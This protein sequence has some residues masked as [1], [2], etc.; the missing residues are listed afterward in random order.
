MTDMK[1]ELVMPFS[2]SQILKILSN[3]L[4]PSRPLLPRF[5]L[6][7]FSQ[8]RPSSLYKHPKLNPSL[9]SARIAGISPQA[10]PSFGKQSLAKPSGDNEES[11][12]RGNDW[13]NGVRNL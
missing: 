1:P 3:P 8:S 12:I 7:I 11:N 5:I 10:K 2:R 6:I 4:L 9:F 13:P